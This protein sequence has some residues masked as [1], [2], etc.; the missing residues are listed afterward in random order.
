MEERCSEVEYPVGMGDKR[1]RTAR[2]R[3]LVG[4]SSWSDRSLVHE[5]DWYPWR[6]MKAAQR[7]AYYADRFGVVEIDATRRFPPTPQL[8][9]QWVERTPEGF[10]M[11]LQAW[12]LLTGDATLPDSLWEDLREEVRPE[13]RDR[14]RLY[15]GHLSR[16][17]R[18]EAWAR[19]RHAILP[20]HDS[21]RLGAVVL[22]YPHWLRPGNTALA[23]MREARAMLADFR[24]AVELRNHHWLEGGRCDETLSFLEDHDL[25]FV[26]V[27]SAH[28]PPVVACTSELAF[29]RFHGRNPG[30]WEDP[31]LTLAE[32][33]AYRYSREELSAWVPKIRDL[34]ASAEEVHVLFANAYRDLAVVNASELAALLA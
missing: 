6:S 22:R 28:A 23:L 30:D 13:L 19:F 27:D 2:G 9:R 10:T 33:Y 8:A 17:G 4:S 20:L 24:L 18:Q 1:S 12:T 29:V 25:C 14:R 7:I 5:S 32:R 11:D 16:D 21:G 15:V 34:A 31:E 26:C 3:V